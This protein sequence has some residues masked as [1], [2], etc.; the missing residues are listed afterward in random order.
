MT[1]RVLF[2][3]FASYLDDANG[4]SVASRAMM[5]ALARRG[6][7]VE[8]LCGPILELNREIDLTSTL[9]ARS[10]SVEVR[11]GDA[12]DVGF[13]GTRSAASDHMALNL[14]SVPVTILAGSA[15]PHVPDEEECRAFLQWFERVWARLRPE[16]VVSYG[17][18]WL[19]RE[20]LRRAKVRGA[21]TVFPLH[22]LRYHDPTT[23]VD[24]DRVLVASQ[25][26][27]E[28]YRKTLGLGCTVLPNLVD[29][30]RARATDRRPA[31]VVF[32]NPT[33]EKGV[34]VFARIADELGRR[35]PD[36]PFLAVEARGTEED[37]AA[38][39]LDLRA[40]GN[41]FFHEHTSDPRRFWRLAKICL[42]PSLVAENQPLVAIEAMINGV[43]VVGSDRGGIPE[44][45]GRGG[46]VLPIPARLTPLSES[47]PTPE[48]TTPWVEAILE[49][50]DS[51]EIYES[52]S[53]RA[54]IEAQRWLPDILEPRYE[55]FFTA[56]GSTPPRSSAGENRV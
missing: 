51:P 48:E 49:L 13:F 6:F 2:V 45:I 20:I 28:H 53:R 17:G 24:V 47:L 19:T 35:P 1:R 7:A 21:V 14:N 36:I 52:S 27:A 10:L 33:I 11:G 15:L 46:S 32:V 40:H 54:T 26:A 55:Q 5:E 39:G 38:C 30:D 25:F 43:P 29:F 3:S 56:L 22:N 31:F 37:V 42:L 50:W 9:A 44:T 4:A 18:G 23:F 16:V 12:W 41:T 8:V 34:G